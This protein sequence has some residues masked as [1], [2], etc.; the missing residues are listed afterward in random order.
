MESAQSE[1]LT[2]AEFESLANLT[3]QTLFDELLNEVT[4]LGLDDVLDV[5]LSA[6]ILSLRF[7]KDAEIIL[8]SHRAAR[9]IWM[10]AARQAWH[11]SYSAEAKH[12]VATKDQSEL[13]QVLGAQLK[14]RMGKTLNLK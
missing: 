12:W 3:L 7:S 10:S 5:D 2:E 4:R 13:K 14:A 9:Q 8:N 6:G 1:A 11:F